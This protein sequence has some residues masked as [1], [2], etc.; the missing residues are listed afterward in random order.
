MPWRARL[1]TIGE[2]AGL[3][4]IR[5]ANPVK[6]TPC[7]PKTRQEATE[8]PGPDHMPLI[9]SWICRAELAAPT[10]RRCLFIWIVPDLIRGDSQ[11]QNVEAP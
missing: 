2:A 1:R 7:T 11:S 9:H 5:P 3:L 8:G 4:G 10:K 6:K